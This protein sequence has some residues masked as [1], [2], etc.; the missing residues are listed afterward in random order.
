MGSKK[1]KCFYCKK[2]NFN[3]FDCKFCNKRFCS[4]CIVLEIHQC[5][6]LLQKKQQLLNNLSNKLHNEKCISSKINKI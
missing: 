1:S 3:L 5:E 2:K 4:S 6:N